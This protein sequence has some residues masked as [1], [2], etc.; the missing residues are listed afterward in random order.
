MIESLQLIFFELEIERQ[1]RGDIGSVDTRGNIQMI[2]GSYFSR[3]LAKPEVLAEC[4]ASSARRLRTIILLTG[5]GKC[6]VYDVLASSGSVDV[7]ESG[8]QRDAILREEGMLD[9]TW[10]EGQCSLFLR[11]AILTNTTFSPNG[12]VM[13]YRC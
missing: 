9:P 8:R 2:S 6:F 3:Y 1:S 4:I 5:P 12:D 13:A 7:K 11:S 10:D